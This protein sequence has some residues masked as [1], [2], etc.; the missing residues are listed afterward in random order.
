[1]TTAMILVVALLLLMLWLCNK[2]YRAYRMLAID[3][4][5]P[6]VF[7]RPKFATFHLPKF[8]N[9]DASEMK[10]LS[11]A[12]LTNMLPRMQKLDGPYGLYGTVY[13]VSTP[14]VHV[15]HGVPA[16]AILQNTTTKAPAYDH[17]FN[18][19]GQGVFTADGPD[20]KAKRT[21]VLHALLRGSH[22]QP[23]HDIT[24][25]AERAADEIVT[26]LHLVAANKS[27][28]L[29][30]PDVVPILQTATVQLI[31]RFITRT[32]LCLENKDAKTSR[33]NDNNHDNNINSLHR[34]L[35][36]ITRIRLIILAQSRSIWFVLPPVERVKPP[37]P[38]RH[39]MPSN[40]CHCIAIA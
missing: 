12:T 23:Q 17:F 15:A 38:V 39:W 27:C 1:M 36:S 14:V 32:E 24:A 8:H 29:S 3:A 16:A 28:S 10:K 35:E 7:W 22:H 33:S 13:G 30:P 2:R 26:R 5:L 31:Y 21:A 4:K 34:Y 19:C 25:L 18:F 40:I 6:T 37:L 9:E 20:W 11:D